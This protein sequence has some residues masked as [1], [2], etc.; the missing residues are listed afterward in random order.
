VS[1]FLYQAAT[2][3]YDVCGYVNLLVS[4]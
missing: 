2:Q 3:G 1:S 4:F